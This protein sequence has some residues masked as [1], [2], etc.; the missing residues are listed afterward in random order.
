MM[1]GIAID[2]RGDANQFA[3]GQ[4]SLFEATATP[5]ATSAQQASYDAQRSPNRST[6]SALAAIARG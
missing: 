6:R 3:N 5:G 2:P 4:L 1:M